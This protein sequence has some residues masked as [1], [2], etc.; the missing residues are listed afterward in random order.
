MAIPLSSID[1]PYRDKIIDAVGF[2]PRIWQ[3]YFRE[4]TRRILPLGLEN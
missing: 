2:I 4:I 1:V 3:E